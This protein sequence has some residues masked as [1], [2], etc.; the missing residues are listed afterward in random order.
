M[1]VPTIY[2]QIDANRRKT[3]LLMIGFSIFIIAIA[4]VLVFALGYEGP[5]ALGFVGIVLIISGFI[6]FGSYYWSDKLVL[7]MTG[8]KPIV[9]KDNPDL[10]RIIE[11]L[12]I[13]S[14]TPMP[15]IY[16]MKDSAPNAFATGRDPKHAAIAFSTGLLSRLEKLELE[17]VAAHELAHVRNYDTRLM[18]IV[19]ILVGTVALLAD[20][21]FRSLWFGGGR[22]RRSGGSLILVLG[23]VVAI[24]AP[25][26]AQLIKFSVS[27]RR[28]FLADSSGALLT[29][30][31]ES[32]ASALLKISSDSTPARHASAAN[33]HMFIISPFKGKQAKSWLV[34][35]F[36]THPPMEERVKALRSSIG[37]S[38]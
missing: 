7:G 5:G 18:S 2:N 38:L 24:L 23:V 35:L 31:P 1:A 26:A 30:N 34:S 9:K 8:A 21:F 37:S 12:T 10:Y 15:K 11:N 3:I 17:G 27:R 25:I 33:A 4:Y 28:E 6:N 19:V 36:Q 29:R 13:A 32:L 20:I 16:V 14:G 22:S